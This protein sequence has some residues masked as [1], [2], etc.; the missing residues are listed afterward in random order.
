MLSN[1][2]VLIDFLSSEI[3]SNV[4]LPSELKVNDH[5]RQASPLAQETSYKKHCVTDQSNI[6]CKNTCYDIN[7]EDMQSTIVRK[8][9][10]YFAAFIEGD[11]IFTS[12]SL[13]LIRSLY[14]YVLFTNKFSI[15]VRL[16]L[17]KILLHFSQP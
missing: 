15:M 11:E 9:E 7:S 6:E 12:H 4:H 5:K 3:Q 16:L 17:I 2:I 14:I 13:A 10:V 1:A 8:A